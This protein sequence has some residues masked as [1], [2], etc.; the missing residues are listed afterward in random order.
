MDRRGCSW[1]KRRGS[2]GG[3]RGLGLP[4]GR[5]PPGGP[6]SRVGRGGDGGPVTDGGQRRDILSSPSSCRVGSGKDVPGEFLPESGS[7]HGFINYS[8]LRSIL[9]SR[10]LTKGKWELAGEQTASWPSFPLSGRPLLLRCPHFSCRGCCA[11]QESPAGQL[12]RGLSIAASPRGASPNCLLR[13]N[14]SQPVTSADALPVP[15]HAPPPSLRGSIAPGTTGF[16]SW[17]PC[18]PSGTRVAPEQRFIC[19][20]AALYTVSTSS[21]QPMA[22]TQ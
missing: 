22:G 18:L 21:V 19:L 4:L 9:Q 14:R 3:R 11:L 15:R 10:D 13:A 20:L 5:A 2:R 7:V 12:P 8:V 6:M 1:Q 16:S 17:C